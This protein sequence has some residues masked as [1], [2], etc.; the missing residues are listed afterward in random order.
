MDFAEDFG[1]KANKYRSTGE[2]KN[3]L[4]IRCQDHPLTCNQCVSYL[5][6]FK[7]SGLFK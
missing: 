7:L 5:D 4:W 1:A 6:N 3:S 2:Y